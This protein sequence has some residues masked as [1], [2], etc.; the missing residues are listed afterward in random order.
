MQTEEQRLRKNTQSKLHYA[1]NLESIRQRHR[2][3]AATHREKQRDYWAQY[4][5]D[6]AEELKAIAAAYYAG[7]RS[8]KQTYA[9][10]HQSEIASGKAARHVKNADRDNANSREYY[11]QHSNALHLYH[12]EYYR[13]HAETIGAWNTAYQKSHPE[14]RAVS[15]EKRRAAKRVNPPRDELLTEIQ[16]HEILEKY[17]YRCAYCGTKLDKPTMDHVIPLSKGGMHTKQNIVPACKHC[18]S[19]KSAKTTIEWRGFD[20]GG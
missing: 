12:K 14:Q 3:Y 18:N 19:S 6:H 1:A 15:V 9:A 16:W 10:E 2:E 4:Q 17:H 20:M 5:I 7:H 11:L 8:E 13:T